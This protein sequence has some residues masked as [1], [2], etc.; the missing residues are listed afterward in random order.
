[1]REVQDEVG[2]DRRLLLVVVRNDQ[3]VL[4]WSPQAQEFANSLHWEKTPAVAARSA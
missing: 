2:L 1:V 3:Q 4:D